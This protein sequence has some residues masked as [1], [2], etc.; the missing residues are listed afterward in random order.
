MISFDEDNASVY[1]NLLYVVYAWTNC[2]MSLVA[3]ALVDQWGVNKAAFLFLAFC[4]VG[5]AL[6]AAACFLVPAGYVSPVLGYVILFFGRFLFGLGGGPITIAQNAIIA[7]WF[8]GKE[9]A[10]AFGIGLSC[11]RLGSVINF[12]ITPGVYDFWNRE[13]P[14]YGLGITLACTSGLVMVSLLA[15]VV[16]NCM[17]IK[18]TKW[19]EAHT[20]SGDED[21]EF[22]VK[23]KKKIRLADIKRFP[24]TYW[25]II[26]LIAA[27]YSIVFPFMAVA[28]DY[29]VAVEKI[30]PSNPSS[31]V[32]LTYLVSM[33]VSPFLGAF[34]DYFGRRG[35]IALLG[36]VLT[37]PIFVLLRAGEVDPIY[38]FLALGVSYSVCA[39]ALWPTLRPWC[40]WKW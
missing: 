23:K 38:L 9:L 4:Q 12:N 35:H 32:S 1:Y 11:S 15:C 7:E 24:K 2:I 14:D 8:G 33:F 21:G 16:Y 17:S 3:G 28:S 22:A 27:F 37:I 5:S 13:Y 20:M 39:A 34:V 6:F 30:T 29:L 10:L 36:S 19:R 40:P 25:L 18:H 26:L 31:I